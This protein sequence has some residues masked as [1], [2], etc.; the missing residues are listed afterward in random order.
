MMQKE[1][2]YK[3]LLAL[4]VPVAFQHLML[5]LVGAADAIMLGRLEQEAMSAVSLAGQVLYVQSLFVDGISVGVGV[6]SSQYFGKGDAESIER[7]LAMVLRVSFCISSVFTAA[8]LLVPRVL[9]RI[10][11]QEEVLIDQ[12]S[13]YLR[14]VGI[15][16][17]FYGISQIYLTIMKNTGKA[18]QAS[19]ITS[20]CVAMNIVLNA[21]LIFGLCGMPQMGIYGAAVSAV[22]SKGMECVLALLCQALPGSIRICG[23]FSGLSP[24]SQVYARNKVL[25]K[26]FWKYA[27]PPLCESL[28]WGI[29]IT[30]Y[31]VIIGHMGE[32]AVAANSLVV[33]VNN[34]VISIMGG[35]KIG[36]GIL[37]GYELGAGRLEQAKR[38]GD[39]CV[40]VAWVT[41]IFSAVLVLLSVFPLRWLVTLTPKAAE[42][43]AGMLAIVAVN[44]LGQAGCCI[45]VGGILSAG[46]DAR[47]SLKVC[48]CTMWGIVLPVAFLG[49]FVL[50]LPILWVYGI[51]YL[52]AN[53]RVFPVLKRYR[54][55]FWVKNLTK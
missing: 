36:S 12:G 42:Y 7:I 14:T 20:F 5:A 38:Y 22:L 3:K 30:L 9:M 26:N 46:G 31:T 27:M 2:F 45:I 23:I 11:T 47:F 52:E 54:K 48:C 41:G 1:S 39:R 28:V 16:Y 34:L 13:R 49:A 32:D 33:I 6:L 50:E 24:K 40:R 44:M 4:A 35:I 25:K 55:Y 53:L 17:L 10:F 18:I 37:I 29:G 51:L 43:M 8:A 19:L 15:C 21:V